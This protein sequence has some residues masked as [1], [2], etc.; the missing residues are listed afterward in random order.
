MARKKKAFRSRPRTGMA[1]APTKSFSAFSDYVRCEVEKKEISG[2]IKDFFKK[3][4]NKPDLKI[5]SDTP[6][7]WYG[8]KTI[9]ASTVAWETMG[10]SFPDNWNPERVKASCIEDA[11]EWAERKRKEKAKEQ[12]NGPVRRK[13]NPTEIIAERTSDFI[14]GVEEVLDDYHNKT[15]EQ[16]MEYSVFHELRLAVAPNSMA[17][18]VYDYYTPIYEE[19]RELVEDKTP[20]LVEAYGYM[21][22]PQ[23]KQYMEFIKQIVDDAEKYMQNKKAM[24]KVRVKKAP[25]ALKQVS[26][27]QYA[28]DSV[29]YKLT[30]INPTQIVGNHRLYTFHVKYKRLTELVSNGK[31]FEISGSTI[32]N[33]DSDL[34]RTISLRKPDEFLQKVLKMTPTQINK[35]WGTLTTKTNPAN[36]RINKETILLRVFDK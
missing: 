11:K 2:I 10:N 24:R 14:G 23:R 20:D 31:G 17:K 7:W 34:S 12:A 21:T 27:I 32:K 22:V 16:A 13:K 15:H 33:F 5:V 30:S 18:A 9:L 28:K 6:D 1:A 26:R 25:T 3:T 29:E 4:L 36:G 8:S 35:E 19:I